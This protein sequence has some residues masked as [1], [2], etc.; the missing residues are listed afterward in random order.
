ME[1]NENFCNIQTAVTR[2]FAIS[3]IFR[4]LY[5][6]AFEKDQ[7]ILLD[8]PMACRDWIIKNYQFIG[9][10]ILELSAE[11]EDQTRIIDKN[12][13]VSARKDYDEAEN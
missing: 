4:D 2:S 10:L 5:F 11:L 13:I 1:N 6:I 7:K 12:V 3:E 8:D 9:N